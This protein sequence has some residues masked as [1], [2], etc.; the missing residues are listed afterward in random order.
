MIAAFAD[1]GLGLSLKRGNSIVNLE[2]FFPA[3]QSPG[4]F[5]MTDI[6]ER[7][8]VSFNAQGLMMTR[9]FGTPGS[10]RGTSGIRCSIRG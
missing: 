3:I 5:P 4:R 8:E 1:L 7:I 10:V 9:S 6:Q 2:Q